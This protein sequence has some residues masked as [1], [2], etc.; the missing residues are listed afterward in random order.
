[1]GTHPI[2]ES[3]FDCLTDFGPKVAT[4]FMEKKT[5][6]S[7]YETLFKEGVMVAEKKLQ[8]YRRQDARRRCRWQW[9][10]SC[11]QPTGHQDPAIADVAWVRETELRLAP[12]LLILTN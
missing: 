2:F 9:Q 4:M 5:R 3:D 1:M 8:T 11:F 12:L 6:I 7:I 10:V